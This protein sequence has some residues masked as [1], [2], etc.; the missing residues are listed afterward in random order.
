MPAGKHAAYM[1]VREE[2]HYHHV[3]EH[4]W[5][6]YEV[7]KT[8]KV[9]PLLQLLAEDAPSISSKEVLTDLAT[10]VESHVQDTVVQ[11]PL[12]RLRKYGNGSDKLSISL[13]IIAMR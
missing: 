5:C 4:D 1:I 11:I 7:K 3:R 10:L 12:H 8:S 6:E 9:Q 13:F 2:I